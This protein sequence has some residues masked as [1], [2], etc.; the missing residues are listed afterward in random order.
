MLAETGHSDAKYILKYNC[1]WP[2]QLQRHT[3]QICKSKPHNYQY[4]SLVYWHHILVQCIG[5]FQRWWT[6]FNL[7]FPECT[8]WYLQWHVVDAWN[9]ISIHGNWSLNSFCNPWKHFV[10]IFV[11]FNMFLWHMFNFSLLNYFM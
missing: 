7:S 6:T 4:L 2:I 8:M 11:E 1:V 3:L 10:I 9:C 5:I